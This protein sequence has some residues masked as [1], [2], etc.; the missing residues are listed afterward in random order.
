MIR[1]LFADIK[2]YSSEDFPFNPLFYSNAIQ[3]KEKK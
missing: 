3:K 2:H 1:I